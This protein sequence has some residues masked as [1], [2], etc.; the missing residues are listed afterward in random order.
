[1]V[2]NVYCKHFRELC[3]RLEHLHRMRIENLSNSLEALFFRDDVSCHYVSYSE[4][5]T[6][7]INTLVF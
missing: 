6:H 4:H 7:E 3:L 1:M 2:K 5:Y